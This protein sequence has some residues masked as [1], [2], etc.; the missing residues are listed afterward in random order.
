M[1]PCKLSIVKEAAISKCFDRFIASYKTWAPVEVKAWVPFV[2]AKP[3]FDESD[4]IGSIPAFAK[5]SFPSNN[6][7]L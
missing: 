6:S 1:I 4:G 2:R 3:S 5:A 7:P